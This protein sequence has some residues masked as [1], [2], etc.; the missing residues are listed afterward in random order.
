MKYFVSTVDAG[1]GHDKRSN[2]EETFPPETVSG[3]P[4][5]TLIFLGGGVWSCSRDLHPETKGETLAKNVELEVISMPRD[6][7]LLVDPFLSSVYIYIFSMEDFRTIF[8]F[9][10]FS[11]LRSIFFQSNFEPRPNDSSSSN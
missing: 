8:A 10:A 2:A 1:K 6:Y 9:P 5:K 4:R 11:H 7:I 3:S